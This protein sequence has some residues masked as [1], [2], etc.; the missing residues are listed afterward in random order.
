MGPKWQKFDKHTHLW[1]FMVYLDNCEYLSI[2]L[3][4][5]FSEMFYETQFSY[6]SNNTFLDLK[7]SIFNLFSTFFWYD[8]RLNL[9]LARRHVVGAKLV[10]F[11]IIGLKTWIMGQVKTQKWQFFTF[12]NG[13]I[14]TFGLC[15]F[16]ISTHNI[17]RLTFETR[18][19][20]FEDYVAHWS[21]NC[22]CKAFCEHFSQTNLQ[23]HHC[24]LKSKSS[25]VV[26]A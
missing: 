12:W 18:V 20:R 10:D 19:M 3:G 13:K 25:C 21:E 8:C 6:V 11:I 9:T 16:W 15:F 4:K 14:T 7:M 23:S 1:T 2:C 22:A 26:L 17:T 5:S 24:C